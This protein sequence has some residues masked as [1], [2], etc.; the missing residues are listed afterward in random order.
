MLAI[1]F[2]AFFACAE[3]DET[4]RTMTPEIRRTDPKNPPKLPISET[5]SSESK[6]GKTMDYPQIATNQ[7]VEICVGL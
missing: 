4:V 3:T 7:F 2:A 6:N 1:I 5:L